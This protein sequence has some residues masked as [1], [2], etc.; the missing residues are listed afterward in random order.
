ML[1]F[2]GTCCIYSVPQS[3]HKVDTEDLYLELIVIEER[4]RIKLTIH[5]YVSTICRLHGVL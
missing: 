1:Y 3:Q 2:G 4:S 5:A